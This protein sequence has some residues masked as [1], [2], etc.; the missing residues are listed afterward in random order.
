MSRTFAEM[1]ELT[2]ASGEKKAA[3]SA[4]RMLLLAFLGGAFIALAGEASNMA[5]YGLLARPETFGIGKCVAGLLFPIGL[6]MVVLGGGE[7]FTGNALMV[8]ALKVRRISLA[9]MVRNWVLVYL[10]NFAGCMAIVFMIGI[11]GQ[12][13]AGGGM[14]GAVTLKIAAGKTSL[15]F[16]P[17][18][19]MG[20][21]C[22]WLVCLAV[23]MA[24]GAKDV[25]GKLFAIF[26]PIW[27]FVTS[28]F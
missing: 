22:N 23:W 9:A 26:F 27:L 3:L 18:F 10:G 5:A 11:S 14:L 25:T 7:L 16:M 13:S 15:A 1:T 2:I 17:A 19:W 20:V 24:C 12:L 8:M 21:L 6:M 28:G 4:G